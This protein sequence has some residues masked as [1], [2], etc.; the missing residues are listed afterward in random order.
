[1]A[2][3]A[4]VQAGILGD[5]REALGDV[6]VLNVNPLTLGIETVGGV[7]T[8]LIERNT[9]IPTKKAQIFS[10]AQDNQPTVTIQVFEGEAPSYFV[11]T[12]IVT[13][14]TL[15]CAVILSLLVC[16]LKVVSCI[17]IAYVI[18]IYN[19]DLF[20]YLFLF[21]TILFLSDLK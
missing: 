17:E 14:M 12:L 5:E 1:M 9:A 20:I 21:F 2:Y 15:L 16:K 8:T 7:M 3:G 4:A 18:Y 6:L 13:T 19:V 11:D 10:T